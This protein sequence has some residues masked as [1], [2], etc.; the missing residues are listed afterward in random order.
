M[1]DRDFV[2]D[3]IRRAKAANCSALV[4]TLDL[5][6]VGQRHKDLRNGLS[7]PPKWRPKHAWQ[8]ATRPFWARE[9]LGTRRRSF[10]N[11]AGRLGGLDDLASIA[12]WTN[13]QYDPRLSWK[14]VA[15]IRERLGRQ[16]DPEGHPRPRGRPDGRRRRRRRASSSPTTAAA[17]STAPARRSR[18][19]PAIVDGG[20]RPDRGASRRRHPLRPG[21]AEGAGARRQGHLYRPRLPLRPRRRRPRRGHP[22]PRDHPQRARRRDGALRPPR[23][24]Q[25]GPRHPR[26]AASRAL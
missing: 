24:P 11:I 9:M 2:L 23:R 16:A 25:P 19:C 6:I 18:R 21:R 13:H 10:G 26:P 17:S 3:L 12:A 5:Q 8:I 14:D 7:V 22:R 1:R 4:L 15:W 20:G